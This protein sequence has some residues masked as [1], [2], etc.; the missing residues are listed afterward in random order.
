MTDEIS[1]RKAEELIQICRL[2][3]DRSLRA[4]TDKELQALLDEYVGSGN[5]TEILGAHT[6][7]RVLPEK[8]DY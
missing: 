2:R 3:D 5:Y 6:D 4:L 8:K 7:Y 1:R